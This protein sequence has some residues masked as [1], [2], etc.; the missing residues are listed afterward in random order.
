MIWGHRNS[1]KGS[2]EFSWDQIGS[3]RSE[4]GRRRSS[5]E[6]VS[7]LDSGRF[8]IKLTNFWRSLTY[9]RPEEFLAPK[10]KKCHRFRS[11]TVLNEILKNKA[12]NEVKKSKL[13]KTI[14]PRPKEF[15][16]VICTHHVYNGVS[17]PCHIENRWIADDERE[18]VKQSCIIWISTSKI[19]S[20]LTADYHTDRLDRT[21]H[22]IDVRKTVHSR[23]HSILFL[24][25]FFCFVL[26]LHLCGSVCS[27]YAE[28]VL[29]WETCR[30]YW[31]ST[32]RVC[33]SYV[34]ASSLPSYCNSVFF[35][36]NL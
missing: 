31:F 36:W 10:C 6:N 27:K 25:N 4:V 20:D 22:I 24:I 34:R 7:K 28:L 23:C 17:S 33:V 26:F 12:S 9:F 3:E 2:D 16:S 14:F 30:T 11:S 32:E 15:F 21:I 29:I 8:L 13:K 18:R 19:Y 5:V 35:L 1:R